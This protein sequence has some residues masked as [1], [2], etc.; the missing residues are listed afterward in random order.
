MRRKSNSIG[1]WTPGLLERIIEG[2]GIEE[3]KGRVIISNGKY[4]YTPSEEYKRFLKH[5]YQHSHKKH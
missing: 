1:T 2:K 5:N 4:K 3:A